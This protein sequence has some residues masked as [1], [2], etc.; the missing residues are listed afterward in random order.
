MRPLCQ[1]MSLAA[2]S[3]H[4]PYLGYLLNF[5]KTRNGFFFLLLL[6][7]MIILFVESISLLKNFW[8]Y[9]DEKKALKEGKS[10]NA[11]DEGRAPSEQEALPDGLQKEPRGR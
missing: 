3:F 2:L 7:C 10:E 11:S 5:M 8:A 4:I 9:Q 6:P 1:R